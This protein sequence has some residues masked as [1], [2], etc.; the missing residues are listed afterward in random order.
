MAPLPKGVED[1]PQVRAA[2]QAYV[3]GKPS[4]PAGAREFW[5][6]W[7]SKRWKTVG[8]IVGDGDAIEFAEAYAKQERE[9]ADAAER[10]VKELEHDL[11]EA[12][13]KTAYFMVQGGPV[14]MATDYDKL[15]AEVESL[16]T[17]L[18]EAKQ[19]LEEEVAS[20]N[21]QID[22]IAADYEKSER[23]LRDVREALEEGLSASLS[24]S[25]K[26]W[27]DWLSKVRALLSRKGEG[28]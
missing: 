8:S 16:R 20:S 7:A 14:V 2:L 12:N 25:V 9:R 4:Q 24:S 22:G 1:T 17:E 26:P 5:P 11:R 27:S 28:S 18:R 15:K 6:E 3:D 13:N 10:R 23:E 19:R 21:R